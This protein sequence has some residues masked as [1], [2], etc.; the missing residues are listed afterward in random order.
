MG[1]ALFEAF[2]PG[3]SDPPAQG[4][5]GHYILTLDPPNA[6]ETPVTYDVL[7]SAAGYLLPVTVRVL[8]LA[9]LSLRQVTVDLDPVSI[10]VAPARPI[11][12][13]RP[14]RTVR[15]LWNPQG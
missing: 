4:E 7:V 5:P 13:A 2:D 1:R 12:P 6:V 14:M 15:R 3:F 11:F 10:P 9:D 8:D